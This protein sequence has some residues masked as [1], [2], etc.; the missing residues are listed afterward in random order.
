MPCPV[1]DNG[2]RV[3]EGIRGVVGCPSDIKTEPGHKQGYEVAFG[4]LDRGGSDA[5]VVVR[6]L[7]KKSFR[8][9][10]GPG[11]ADEDDAETQAWSHF[12]DNVRKTATVS[13]VSAIHRSTRIHACRSSG[14]AIALGMHNFR[15]VDDVISAIGDWLDRMGASGEVMLVLEPVPNPAE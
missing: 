2:F 1:S 10:I 15:D 12:A 9:L 8:Q 7:G 6:G 11:P 14:Y 4:C 3:H 13:T 5:V